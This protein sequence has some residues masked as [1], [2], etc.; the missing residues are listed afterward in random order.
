MNEIVKHRITKKQA[1][2][3]SKLKIGDHFKF[4]GEEYI[5]MGKAEKKA[6][7]IIHADDKA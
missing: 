1:A 4:R 5:F 7:W 3:I 6:E 2:S